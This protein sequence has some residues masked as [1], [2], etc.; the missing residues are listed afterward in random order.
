MTKK[1]EHAAQDLLDKHGPEAETIA[2]R[3]YETALEMQDLKQ[4]GYWLDIL[5]TIKALKASKA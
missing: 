1:A 5:D 4:Q 3:E 2:T